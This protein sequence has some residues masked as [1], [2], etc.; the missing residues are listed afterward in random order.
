MVVGAWAVMAHGWPR[1]SSDIDVVVQLPFAKRKPVVDLLHAMGYKELEERKDEWGQR[2]V[3]QLADNLELE[4]FFTPPRPPYDEEYARRVVIEVEGE[5]VPFLS[6]EDL[7]IR[8]LV[9]T[10]LRRS[11]DLDDVIGVLVTKRGTLD[12]ERIRAKA[13]FDRVEAK[14]NEAIAAAEATE[15]R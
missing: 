15:R 8:K 4:V 12:M 9:N 7:V 1:S 13:T 14:L 2:V 10:R 11:I 3:A 5:P 6:P